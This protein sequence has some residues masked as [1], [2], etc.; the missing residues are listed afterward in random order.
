MAAE[1]GF[2]AVGVVPVAAKVLQSCLDTYRLFSEAKELGSDSQS[3]IW[4]F[5]IQQMSN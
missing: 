1:L 2:G 5:R 4:K 3:L